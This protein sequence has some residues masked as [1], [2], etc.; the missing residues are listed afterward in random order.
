MTT[1][2]VGSI[3]PGLAPLHCTPRVLAFVREWSLHEQLPEDREILRRRVAQLDAELV[4]LARAGVWFVSRERGIELRDRFVP[5]AA[6]AAVLYGVPPGSDAVFVIDGRGVVRFAYEPGG[7][8][9]ATLAAAFDAAGEALAARDR[10]TRMERVL[11]SRREWALTCLVVGCTRTFVGSCVGRASANAQP[12]PVAPGATQS[13]RICDARGT[14]VEK[15][16][17][18]LERR[19]LARGTEPTGMRAVA[20]EPRGSSTPCGVVEAAVSR[21]HAAAIPVT[22]REPVVS[23]TKPRAGVKST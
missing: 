23:P 1:V 9:D 17:E 10:H 5:D 19:R 11:F 3:A 13:V 12:V 16:E 6:T 21:E 22:R 14:V 18:R 2:H 20:R 8:L 4:V 15:L 7:A